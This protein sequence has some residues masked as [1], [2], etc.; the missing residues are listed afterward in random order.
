MPVSDIVGHWPETVGHPRIVHHDVLARCHR[1]DR[2]SRAAVLD[3]V[4][5]GVADVREV[6]ADLVRSARPWLA[7]HRDAP[8]A[9]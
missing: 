3:V 6:R 9:R 4:G 2:G 7:I 8:L 5:D 1:A